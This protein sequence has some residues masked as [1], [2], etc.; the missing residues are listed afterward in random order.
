MPERYIVG[1][2]SL[3]MTQIRYLCTTHL[4]LYPA[5]SNIEL[6]SK[7]REV[8]GFKGSRK[9]VVIQYATLLVNQG[10]KVPISLARV[11]KR[12]RLAELKTVGKIF[13]AK[14]IKEQNTP[15]VEVVVK[16]LES[17]GI[18]Y[19]RE[20]P[21]VVNKK[22]EPG[23]KKLYLIDLYLPRPIMCIIELDGN[24]HYTPEGRAYDKVRD[25]L[26]RKKEI[27]PIFRIENK[28][29][30]APGFD[31]LKVLR[32]GKYSGQRIG[33]FLNDKK[34]EEQRAKELQQQSQYGL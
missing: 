27:G 32:T 22:G 31:I 5:I 29:A 20:Y 11:Q 16:Q 4:K 26:I 3:R 6:A 15:A 10:H 33:K 9:E 18:P 34:K 12:E 14:N 21:V 13:S 17:M 28:V 1:S 2:K 30:L 25:A 7:I 23:G 8:H 19:I 24:G